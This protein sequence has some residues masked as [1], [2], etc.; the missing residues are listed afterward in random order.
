MLCKRVKEARGKLEIS[1]SFVEA[2]RAGR[3]VVCGMRFSDHGYDVS[4]FTKERPSQPA[5]LPASLQIRHQLREKRLV[6]RGLR[7]MK[8]PQRPARKRH[9][10]RVVGSVW[11]YM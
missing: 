2:K 7:E 8:M 9:G 11:F 1:F 4:G 5:C 6:A 10:W 3:A